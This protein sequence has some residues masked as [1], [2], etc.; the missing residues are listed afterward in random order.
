MSLFPIPIS[1]ALRI[2]KIQRDFLWGRMG[3]GKKFHL[4]NWSQVC[5]PLKMGGLGVRN[6]RIF[7]QALMGKWLWRYGNEEDAFW[8]HLIFVKYGRE[9]NG[10]YGISLWKHIRKGWGSFACHLH[11]EVGDGTKTKFWDDIW[12]GTCS[13]RNAF[14]ELHRIAR[15][16]DAVVGDLIQFQNGVVSWVLDFT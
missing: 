8:S 6:L 16:K 5:Q 1:V 9:V 7:N 11:F 3:E 13:L 10:P 4:V 14:L 12:C 15:H 2:D